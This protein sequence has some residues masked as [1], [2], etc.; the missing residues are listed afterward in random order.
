MGIGDAFVPAGQADAVLDRG[1]QAGKFIALDG[2]HR[3]AL[4]DQIDTRHEVGVSA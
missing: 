1:E 3:R 4:E 2:G